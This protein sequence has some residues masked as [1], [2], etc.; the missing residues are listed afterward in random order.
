MF[1]PLQFGYN[2]FELGTFYFHR[3]RVKVTGISEQ[4]LREYLKE[5]THMFSL[6]TRSKWD[7]LWAENQYATVQFCTVHTV[8]PKAIIGKIRAVAL[9]RKA[10]VEMPLYESKP[11][12]GLK[13][14]GQDE[15][16]FGV[17][18]YPLF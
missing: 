9:A 14:K 5:S 13:L 12:N 16:I 15:N 11:L 10:G 6:T 7:Q 3:I 17:E 4:E 8:N 18:E 2:Q 1:Q